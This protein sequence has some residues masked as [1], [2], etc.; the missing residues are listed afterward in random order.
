MIKWGKRLPAR[1]ADQG[2]SAVQHGVGGLASSGIAYRNYVRCQ[3]GQHLSG[4]DGMAAIYSYE[5][6]AK[7][8]R[9]KLLSQT[10]DSE[11]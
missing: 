1:K 10:N 5:K 4:Q 7:R 3:C 2:H 9:A 8:E 6:H 11:A